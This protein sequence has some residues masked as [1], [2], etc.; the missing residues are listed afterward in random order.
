M[1]DRSTARPLDRSTARLL[2][3]S[4]QGDNVGDVGGRRNRVS[5]GRQGRGLCGSGSPFRIRDTAAA[6]MGILGSMGHGESVRDSGPGRYGILSIYRGCHFYCRFGHLSI[7]ASGHLGKWASDSLGS[8]RCFLMVWC[9]FSNCR[10]AW[11]HAC[12]LSSQDPHRIV[13]PFRFFSG[14][15]SF[16]LRKETA[17]AQVSHSFHATEPLSSTVYGHDTLMKGT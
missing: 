8:T 6:D 7:W 3:R 11:L 17:I 16:C 4:S 1:L 5:D 15:C 9:A 14:R 12:F 2:D 13:P 10:V